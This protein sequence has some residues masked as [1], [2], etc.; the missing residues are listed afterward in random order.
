M[1]SREEVFR[2]TGPTS[3][4]VIEVKIGAKK[5]GTIVAAKLV[6]KYQAGAFPGS[7]VGP[8]CMC[9][10]AMYDLPNV[11][12]TGY[13]V[14]SQ[15]A[16]GRGLSRAGRAELVLRGRKRLDELARQARHRPARIAREE[17]GQGRHQDRARADL[18]QYRLSSQTLEAAKQPRAHW[19]RRCGPNQ[20]RGI[21]SRVLV[22]HRRRIERRGAHQRGRH[23]HVVAGSPDIG[24][25]RASMAMMAA[26]VLGIPIDGCARSSP[27]PP[28]SASPS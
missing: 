11:E 10:F 21:A 18:P 27:T 2:G 1:M 19:K 20:G 16:Q 13:D 12:I 9:G 3:G 6:L 8:G 25:S 28:R 4:G 14:V 23:R 17:R 26:E 22:Q 5:D 15:P 7:P 24:G